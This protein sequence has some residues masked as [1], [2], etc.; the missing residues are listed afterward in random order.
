MLA[1]VRLGQQGN[2]IYYTTSSSSTRRPRRRST[3]PISH[4]RA[5]P[6]VIVCFDTAARGPAG[7][8]THHHYYSA[9]I[10]GTG[11]L[12]LARPAVLKRFC[13]V[14]A[15]LGSACLSICTKCGRNSLAQRSGLRIGLRGRFILCSVAILAQTIKA[16]AQH[17][18]LALPRCDL[19]WR[20]CR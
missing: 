10:P 14:G 2:G 20:S 8:E 12:C 19:A 9:R 7:P 6:V 4:D 11:Q 16:S 3:A 17:F 13:S 18:L 5:G 1:P 15:A